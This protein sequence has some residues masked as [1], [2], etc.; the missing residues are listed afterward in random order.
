MLRFQHLMFV[1]VV[2]GW[3]GAA[4]GGAQPF[5]LSWSTIDGGGISSSSGGALSMAATLGQ[6][7][8]GVMT[9]GGFVLSGGFW[10]GAV[11]GVPLSG[12]CDGDGDVDLDDYDG[13][14]ACLG[15]PEGGVGAGCECFDFD[16]DGDNDLRDFAH[17]Q[18]SFS[19]S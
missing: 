9:G 16:M 1:N 14:G 8:T 13:L 12:D 5:D 19:G 15:G 7:D 4:S 17:F 11:A 2:V 18:V 10:P 6:P 3:L